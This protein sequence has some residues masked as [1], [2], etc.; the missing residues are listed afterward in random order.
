MKWFPNRLV[1]ELLQIFSKFATKLHI[2]FILKVVGGISGSNNHTPN[3]IVFD[4]INTLVFQRAAV[5]A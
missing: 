1:V 5:C 4:E 3:S 2:K